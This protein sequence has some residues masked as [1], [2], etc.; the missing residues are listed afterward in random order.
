MP[1]PSDVAGPGNLLHDCV[2]GQMSTSIRGLS[3]C[4]VIVTLINIRF[5]VYPPSFPPPYHSLPLDCLYLCHPYTSSLFFTSALEGGEGS[6]SRPGRTS[7]PG[8]TRYPLYRR[9]G[10]LQGRSGQVRKI[11]LLPGIDPR[12]FQHVDSCYIDYATGPTCVGTER[13]CLPK[14]L[15]EF[16]FQGK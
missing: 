6:A 8:E 15:F 2:R 12:T 13:N 10:G 16:F 1:R 11:S 7:P 4:D 5:M 9:L 3:T 14:L